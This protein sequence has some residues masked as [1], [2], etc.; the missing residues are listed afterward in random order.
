[1]LIRGRIQRTF[2]R[3]AFQR[4]NIPYSSYSNRMYQLNIHSLQ[5]RRVEYDLVCMFKIINGLSGLDFNEFFFYHNHTHELRNGSRT[6]KTKH[7]FNTSRWN[8]SFFARGVKLWNALPKDI[9]LSFTLDSFKA[10]IK[11]Y[12]LNLITTLLYPW[13]P[14]LNLYFVSYIWKALFTCFTLLP[15]FMFCCQV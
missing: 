9:K 7:H 2:T 12:D 13:F 10:R 11:N 1:M 14:S 3:Y 5:Y 6:I 4:C 8:N 15:I